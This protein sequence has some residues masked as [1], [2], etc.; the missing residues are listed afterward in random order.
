MS[1]SPEILP[2]ASDN[3]FPPIPYEDSLK[4][5]IGDETVDS[6]KVSKAWLDW[7]MQVNWGHIGDENTPEE[8][9]E[10]FNFFH[11]SCVSFNIGTDV[12]LGALVRY[13]GG[14]L[15]KEELMDYVELVDG[16]SI[17]SCDDNLLVDY[18]IRGFG[19]REGYDPSYNAPECIIKPEDLRGLSGMNWD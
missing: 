14:Y 12:T 18:F 19:K 1:D 15:S 7:L 8:E 11:E 17:A 5:L 4:M 6:K 2:S 13:F 16:Y 3:K 9:T 10:A